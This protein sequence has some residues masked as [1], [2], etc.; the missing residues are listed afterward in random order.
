M[1]TPANDIS[2]MVFLRVIP[3][4]PSMADFDKPMQEV[5]ALLNGHLTIGQ[6]SKKS[7]L[8]IE[9]I[10]KALT[11]LLCQGLAVPVTRQEMYVSAQ[12]SKVLRWRLSHAVGPAAEILIEDAMKSM[13]I[14]THRIP[15]HLTVELIEQLGANIKQ[16]S[17]R[18]NYLGHMMAFLRKEGYL[19][20]RIK[21]ALE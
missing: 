6:L 8:T 20:S 10:R 9:Q 18:H 4:N 5:F 17:R 14:T 15:K 21:G 7:G 12:F 3:K 19:L 13:G 1:K 16:N 11:G 2:Q